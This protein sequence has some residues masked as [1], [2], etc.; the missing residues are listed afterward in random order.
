MIDLT[1]NTPAPN[2][3]LKGA[4]NVKLFFGGI[5]RWLMY[6]EENKG[7]DYFVANMITCQTLEQMLSLY[8]VY[9]GLI[10]D[11]EHVDFLPYRDRYIGL[12]DAMPIMEAFIEQTKV[13]EAKQRINDYTDGIELTE[14]QFRKLVKDYI[15]GVQKNKKLPQKMRDYII[16]KHQKMLEDYLF[17]NIVAGVN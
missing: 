7:G 14:P 1:P 4:E 3:G 16:A 11:W 6:Y 2:I 10:R 5:G 9:A 13:K 12:H 8:N 17:V 15:D